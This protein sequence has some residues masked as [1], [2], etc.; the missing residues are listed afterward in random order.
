MTAFSLTANSARI[1]GGIGGW[2]EPSGPVEVGGVVWTAE[3]AAADGASI[4]LALALES[5]EIPECPG[6]SSLLCPDHEPQPATKCEACPHT[7]ADPHCDCRVDP[8]CVC[9]GAA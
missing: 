7:E 9:G 5:I 6:C 3:D 1:P 8:L 2:T 4:G